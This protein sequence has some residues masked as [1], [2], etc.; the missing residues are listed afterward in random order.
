MHVSTTNISK[1][2]IDGANFIIARNMMSH[3]GFRSV[4]LELTLAYSIGDHGL[5]NR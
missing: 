4:N 1:M 5:F 2:V 3:V